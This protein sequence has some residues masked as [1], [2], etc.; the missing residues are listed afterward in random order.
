[1]ISWTLKSF[2]DLKV[3]ELYQIMALR[4]EVFVVEQN[5]VYQDLDGKDQKSWHLMGSMEGSVVAYSRLLPQGI[6]Y[7]DASIGRVV[8]SPDKRRLGL[9]KTLMQESIAS[10]EKLFNTKK[11]RISAQYYLLDFYQSLGF[12]AIGESYLEDGIP[13]QEMTIG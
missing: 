12:V 2:E 6:S 8:T 5:C 13:H 1:M 10:I 7:S 11:I 9:G 3:D 4:S